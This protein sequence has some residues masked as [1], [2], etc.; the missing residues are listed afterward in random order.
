[1]IGDIAKGTTLWRVSRFD[2]S[3]E[4]YWAEALN[5]LVRKANP[6]LSAFEPVEPK[7]SKW[8]KNV[9]EHTNIDFFVKNVPNFEELSEW[10]RICLLGKAKE[11]VDGLMGRELKPYDEEVKEGNLFLNEGINEIWNIICG[12]GSPT[13]YSNANARIGVGNSATAPAATQTALQGGSTAFKAM[14]TTYPTSGSSQQAVFQGTFGTSDANFAWS[15]ETIDNGSSPNK[16]IQRANT[17]LGTKP[18]T[19]TWILQATLTIS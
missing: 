11:I 7:K 5:T 2:F 14:D 4:N 13:V 3:Y 10:E 15:E 17:S 19:E 9:Y 18:G 8:A 6:N 1:M 12:N 16:N